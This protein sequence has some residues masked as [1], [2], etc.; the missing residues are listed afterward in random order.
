LHAW[1]FLLRFATPFKIPTY[2]TGSLYIS[3]NYVEHN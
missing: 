3:Y 1:H 2:F